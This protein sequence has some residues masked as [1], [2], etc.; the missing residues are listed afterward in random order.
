MQRLFVQA[1]PFKR[2]MEELGTETGLLARI[3]VAILENPKAGD[4]IQGTGGVRKMRMADARRGKGK[5]GGYR[6][7]YLDLPDKEHVHLLYI[8]SKDERD[9]LSS[10]GKKVIR[11]LVKKIKES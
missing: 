6:V 1:T 5:R 7:L 10:E 8:Y 11:E 9:D 2:A 4:V 3:E